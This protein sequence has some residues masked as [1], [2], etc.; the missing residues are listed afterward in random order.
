[1]D[2]L[3]FAYLIL[4]FITCVCDL[5]HFGTYSWFLSLGVTVNIGFTWRHFNCTC[6]IQ[7]CICH[8]TA[9]WL[10]HSVA[11]TPSTLYLHLPYNTVP[12]ISISENPTSIQ[13]VPICFYYSNLQLAASLTAF[14]CY[15]FPQIFC[16]TSSCRLLATILGLLPFG[17]RYVFLNHRLFCHGLGSCCYYIIVC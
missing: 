6:L 1:M 3:S 13:G 15:R 14:A 9:D 4:A 5:L 17:I 2:L 16:L 8:R 7:E 12:S 10:T 11:A